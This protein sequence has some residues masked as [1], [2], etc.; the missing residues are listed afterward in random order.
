VGVYK[1][2]VIVD[3]IR[4]GVVVAKAIGYGLDG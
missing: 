3:G 4:R 2:S 1:A